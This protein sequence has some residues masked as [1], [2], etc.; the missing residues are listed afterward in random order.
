[1][2]INSFCQGWNDL[3]FGIVNSNAIPCLQVSLRWSSRET[4]VLPPFLSICGGASSTHHSLALPLRTASGD[5]TEGK[6]ASLY[7]VV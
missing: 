7:L 4:K 6:A 3:P 2:G 5:V 1:M